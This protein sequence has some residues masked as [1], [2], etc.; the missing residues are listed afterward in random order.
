MKTDNE[1]QMPFFSRDETSLGG[2]ARMGSAAWSGQG[3]TGWS[4]TGMGTRYVSLCPWTPCSVPVQLKT[5]LFP[6]L[7]F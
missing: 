1:K 2:T 6:R 5:S 3:L 4:S 7:V